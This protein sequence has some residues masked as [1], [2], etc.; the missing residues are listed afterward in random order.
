[1]GWNP[2]WPPLWRGRGGSTPGRCA[3][4]VAW[5]GYLLRQ[6]VCCWEPR[7]GSFLSLQA[8][9]LHTQET[10]SHALQKRTVRLSSLCVHDIPTCYCR[11]WVST[12]PPPAKYLPTCFTV[13]DRWHSQQA[14]PVAVSTSRG[15][16]STHTGS[17]VLS[18]EMFLLSCCC[19]LPWIQGACPPTYPFL[20][21]MQSRERG[22]RGA[23]AEDH[24]PH[25]IQIRVSDG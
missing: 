6:P 16:I 20:A 25:S 5:L 7:T 19:D 4:G 24:V 2:V 1:M 15:G 17:P 14:S 12:C 18:P 3:F 22:E 23:P 13:W 8:L 10:V 11:A 9:Q 21:S